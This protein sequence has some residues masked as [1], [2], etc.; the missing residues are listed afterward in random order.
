MYCLPASG[1]SH[2]Q[3]Q[4]WFVCQVAP[5]ADV[6]SEA[7]ISWQPKRQKCNL[8]P[9]RW[10][11]N[12]PVVTLHFTT[13]LAIFVNHLTFS[14]FHQSSTTIRRKLTSAHDK[15]HP[16]IDSRPTGMKTVELWDASATKREILPRRT[17]CSAECSSSRRN[18]VRKKCRRPQR[19]KSNP[20]AFP[21]SK[22]SIQLKWPSTPSS[23]RHWE[24]LSQSTGNAVSS[25]ND[26][27]S[28]IKV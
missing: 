6:Y 28:R 1:T 9:S 10:A 5:S 8:T 4:K 7:K 18:G 3:Q 14:S 2:S 15:F 11:I 20:P 27:K 24:T 17:P 19:S 25:Q 12:P 22:D 13:S 16:K 23:G 21:A 26:P